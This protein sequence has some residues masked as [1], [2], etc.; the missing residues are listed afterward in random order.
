MQARLFK[1]A[2]QDPEGSKMIDSNESAA[3]WK[4]VRL[5]VANQDCWA[6]DR[7]AFIAE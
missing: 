3:Q 1:F 4:N 5:C 6:D 7:I 2:L